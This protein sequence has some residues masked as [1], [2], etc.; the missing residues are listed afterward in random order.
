RAGKEVWQRRIVGVR[1]RRARPHRA[2]GPSRGDAQED[3]MDL[4][5]FP[6]TLEAVDTAQAE[7]L[8][9]FVASDERPLTGLS[10][11]ADWRLSGKLSRLLRSGILTGRAGEA[12]LTPPGSR[13]AFQKMFLFGL[14]PLDQPED[15]LVAQV[16]AALHKLAEAGAQVVAM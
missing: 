6:L 5:F 7:S 2:H 9:L 12:V 14:G 11:L 1:E 13:L 8:C 15:K 4:S 16:D 3:L 10:G